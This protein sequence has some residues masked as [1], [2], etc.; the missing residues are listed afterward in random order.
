M[1]RWLGC[2]AVVCLL[3]S[4]M[5][6]QDTTTVQ[7]ADTTLPSRPVPTVT[8]GLQEAIAQ[9]RSNSPI[10]RQTLNDAAP[11]RW[12]VRNAYANFLPTVSV[13]GD[14]GY[15]GSGESNIGGGLTVGT[16]AF[17]T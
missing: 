6:A 9:A 17:L 3:P 4:R 12:G 11:A 2:L 8:L 16:S 14:V 5:G 13:A 15:V 10:Y 7:R 1:N